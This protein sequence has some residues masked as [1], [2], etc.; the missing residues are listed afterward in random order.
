MI[1]P[2][3]FTQFVLFTDVAVGVVTTVLEMTFVAIADSQ[4]VAIE[5][6]RTSYEPISRPVYDA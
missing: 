3:G 5:R 1:D 2:F 6:A 4:P